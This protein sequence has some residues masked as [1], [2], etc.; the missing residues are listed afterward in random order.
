MTGHELSDAFLTEDMF[1]GDMLTLMQPKSGYRAGIDAVLL[2]AAAR[3][4]GMRA[5]GTTSGITGR[6]RI[7]DLGAGVGTVGLCAAVRLV[8]ADVVLAER[9]P[10]LVHLAK[11]NIAIN[12]LE[13]RVQVVEADITRPQREIA[14]VALVADDFTHV[15]AN[16]PYHETAGG[17]VS[18]APL[19]A[20][21]HAMPR[22]DLEHWVK[23]MARYCVPGGR[24]TM[25]HKAD[26]LAQIL[27]V[28]EGRFGDIRVRPVYPRDGVPAIR[29]LIEGIK[30]SRAPMSI[31][32]GFVLH[33]EGH[34]FTPEA[35]AILRHGAA[36]DV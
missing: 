21:S 5:S 23:A 8:E 15:L 33:G 10:Q 29:V 6:P 36:L 22:D 28:F 32:P 13:D 34:G 4:G 2:A 30:G 9:E 14:S 11:R 25:I 24:A 12:G 20:A 31:S 3:A 16:P 19:K 27:S 17:T 7:L 26:A 18:D 1:L 35:E